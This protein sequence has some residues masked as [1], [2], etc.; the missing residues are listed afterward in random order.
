MRDGLSEIAD[1]YDAFII[2]IFGVLHDGIKPFAHTIKTLEMLKGA[3]KTICL[4]S[5]SPKRA[6]AAIQQMLRMGIPRTLYDHV[7]TSGEATHAALK[8]RSDDFHRECGQDCW[9][10]GTDTMMGVLE[11]LN[12]RIVSTPEQASFILNTIPGTSESDARHLRHNFKI[13]VD[14]NLPMICA[15]PDLVVNIGAEQFQCAG[16]FAKIYEDMGGRVLYHG[17]P[18]AP[19]YERCRALLG[20]LEKSRILAIGDSLHTD[21]QGANRFGIAS[22]LVLSGIH[23]DER[24]IEALVDGQPH[25]PNYVMQELMW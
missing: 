12:L 15:N 21:I 25:K 5:N 1:R 13:A 22:V 8:I 7:V 17:K 3:G 18:H 16:T 10:I 23:G 20:G 4:L 6:D 11:G 19:V 24:D 9:F 2:D 14:K